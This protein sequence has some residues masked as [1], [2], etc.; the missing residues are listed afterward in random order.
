[1][2]EFETPALPWTFAIDTLFLAIVSTAHFWYM[3]GQT[4]WICGLTPCR[5]ETHLTLRPSK[6]R[7]RLAALAKLAPS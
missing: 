6:H 1:M 3:R 7:L 2:R 5:E 4:F